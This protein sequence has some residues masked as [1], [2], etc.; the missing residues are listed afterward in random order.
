M[1]KIT[2][3]LAFIFLLTACSGKKETNKSENN[4]AFLSN[5]KTVEASLSNREVELTLTGKVD[6]DPER[7][8]HYVP[9][10]Q[11]VVEQTR[12]SLGDKVQK[13]QALLDIKSSDVSA[14]YSDMISLESDLGVAKRDL[15]SAQGMHDDKML[16]DKEFLESQAKFRQAQVA[17]ERAQNNMSLYKLKENGVFSILSPMTGY[18]VDKQVA[19]GSPISPDGGSLFTVADLSKVWI[20]ASV[21]A[22]DLQFVQENMSVEITALSY[23]GEVFN[24]KINALS[25]VFDPDEKVLKARIVMDNSQLKFK[26]EMSVIVRL[27]NT[28]VEKQVTIPSKALIFDNDKYFVVVEKSSGEFQ[29]QPVELEGNYDSMSYIRSGLQEKDKVVVENQLLIYSGLS[30]K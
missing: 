13:G 5:V 8:I 20:T 30:G 11:G 4:S 10:V 21:Y 14:L 12:F 6:Y 17:Y 25:Q 15:Q 28:K 2:Y 29:I 22:G 16:S 3:S 27:K 26:P 23:P 9:L 18:I 19:S 24:G 7:V 1:G